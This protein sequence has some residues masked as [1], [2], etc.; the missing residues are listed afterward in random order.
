MQEK[1]TKDIDT[2]CKKLSRLIEQRDSKINHTQVSLVATAERMSVKKD[3]QLRWKME[4][5]TKNIREKFFTI[6]FLA[7]NGKLRELE[8]LINST[9]PDKV[10]Y[11][12]SL[13]Q[14]GSLI[15]WFFIR[16]NRW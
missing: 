10:L 15:V 5:S 7:D 16:C 14:R 12:Y 8:V 1:L 3:S 6:W 9:P 11:F 2:L 4:K 13:I